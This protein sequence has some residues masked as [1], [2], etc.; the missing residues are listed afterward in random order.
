VGIVFAVPF[1]R[2]DGHDDPETPLSAIVAHVRHAV[3]VAGIDHVALGSDFDG[4]TMPAPLGDVAGL[5]RLVAALRDDGFTE[6]EV[7]RI[8]WGNWRRVLGQAWR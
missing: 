6:A 3:T 7:E 4:A 5:P 1:I 2:A 8:A